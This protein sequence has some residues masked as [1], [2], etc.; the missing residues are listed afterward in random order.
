MARAQTAKFEEF[1]LEVEFDPTGAPNVYTPI[2]GLI[3]VEIDR[4]S[5]LDEA[6]IPDCDDE[7]LPLS[8]EVQV[9]SQTV[10]VTG[11]GSWARQNSTLMLTWWRNGTT[12]NA[13]LRNENVVVN[14][15]TGDITHEYGPAILSNLKNR[16][17]KGVKVTA[18]LEIRF[19]GV[20]D[21]TTK[22]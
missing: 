8:V 10:T 3:D 21:I 18:E 19:D 13:R 11:T 2:C 5:N 7:S 14:G 16:R 4:V 6:E 15:V 9:R 22:A 17:D 1:I 20:P 12:L